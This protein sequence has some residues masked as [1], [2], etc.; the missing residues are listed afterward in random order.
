M[1]DW[2]LPRQGVGFKNFLSCFGSSRETSLK[3][4]YPAKIVE[5]SGLGG[6]SRHASAEKAGVPS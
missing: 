2:V 4:G 3:L 5:C 6:E 1:L